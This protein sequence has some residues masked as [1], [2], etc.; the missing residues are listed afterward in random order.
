MSLV[1]EL[2]REWFLREALAPVLDGYDHVVIDTPPNLGLLTVNA[3]VC[4]DRVLAPVSVEDEASLHGIFELRQTIAKLAERLGVTV[5]DLAAVLTR[6]QRHR[7]SS[8]QTEAALDAAQLA[9]LARI[10]SRSALIARAAARRVPLS[11]SE[12]DSSPAIAYG[13]LVETIVG[14]STR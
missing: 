10:P 9:Q 7:I 13:T 3:L 1:G 14:V 8:R 2:G 6:W 12:P 5:P 4:A 11:L